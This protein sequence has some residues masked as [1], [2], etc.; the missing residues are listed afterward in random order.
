VIALLLVASVTLSDAQLLAV[1]R[2]VNT[3]IR[4]VSDVEQ[5]G[6]ADKWVVEPASGKGDCEDYAL[7]KAW[8]LHQL[9]L[10]LEDMSL[11]TVTGTRDL[12]MVLEVGDRVLDSRYA[13]LTRS[14]DYTPLRVT[15]VTTGFER[16]RWTAHKHKDAQR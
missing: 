16:A 2:Q 1:H 10:P 5:Y 15:S 9:G 6:W 11:L 3:A 13:P 7:T 4:P 8:R 14:R 12:H